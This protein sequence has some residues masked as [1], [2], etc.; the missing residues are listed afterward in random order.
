MAVASQASPAS[1]F[2]RQRHAIVCLAA[3]TC[4]VCRLRADEGGLSLLLQSAPLF[5][6]LLCPENCASAMTASVLS[7]SNKDIYVQSTCW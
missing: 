1:L 6:K 5:R 2:W 3:V 4:F 7:I